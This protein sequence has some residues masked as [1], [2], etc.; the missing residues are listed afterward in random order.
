MEAVVHD[1]SMVTAWCAVHD[2]R[3]AVTAWSAVVPDLG[4]VTAQSAGSYLKY[5]S[6]F[7]NPL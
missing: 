7:G 1:W 3:S 6:I 4:M 5:G 2:L